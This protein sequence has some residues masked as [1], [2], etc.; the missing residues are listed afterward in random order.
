VGCDG[1][2]EDVFGQDAEEVRRVSDGRWRLCIHCCNTASGETERSRAVVKLKN[3]LNGVKT[4]AELVEHLGGIPGERILLDPV[5]GTATEDDVI[6]AESMREKRICELIDGVLVEKAMGAKESLLAAFIIGLL[7]PFVKE[8]DLG[9]ILTEGGMLRLWPGRVRIPDVCFIAWERLSGNEFPD[10]AIPDIAPDL[11]IE[12]LSR[13]NKKEEMRLKRRDYFQSGVQ[14]VWEIQ[15]K[16]QTAEV[17][18][19]LTKRR[20]IGKDGILDGGDILPGFKLPMKE[21][22][23]RLRR[24]K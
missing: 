20:R 1:R 17:Y 11:A 2:V 19:S 9:V 21:L 16:T 5:P 14:A 24:K 6:A 4:V 3:A 23:A 18:T 12:V 10:E 13:S 8:H 22:F 15:P 7:E